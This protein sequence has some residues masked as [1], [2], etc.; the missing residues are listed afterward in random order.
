MAKQRALFGQKP[1]RSERKP[2]RKVSRG[3]QFREKIR[4]VLEAF[5]PAGS[6]GKAEGKGQ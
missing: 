5:R 6:E 1:G 3:E 4:A 2:P